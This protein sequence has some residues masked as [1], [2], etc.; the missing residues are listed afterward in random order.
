MTEMRG[1]TVVVTGGGAGVGRAMAAAFDAAGAAV[2]VVDVDAD[3]LSSCPDE[4]GRHRFDVSDE[5]R[6]KAMLGDI[7]GCDILC[8]N[9]GVAGPTAPAVDVSLEDWRACMEINLDAPFLINR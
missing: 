1:K 3:A 2:H 6:I 9:A 8:A 4:W 5:D 7:G